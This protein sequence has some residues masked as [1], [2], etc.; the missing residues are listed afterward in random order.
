M[1]RVDG[2]SS[3]V[4]RGAPYFPN[5]SVD[6]S[7]LAP[8]ASLVTESPRHHRRVLRKPWSPPSRAGRTPRS[9]GSSR[10]ARWSPASAATARSRTY[11]SSRRACMS[12]FSSTTPIGCSLGSASARLLCLLRAS[13]AARLGSSSLPGSSQEE[14]GP[15]LEAPTAIALGARMRASRL[16]TRR[17]SQHRLRPCT[18]AYLLLILMEWGYSLFQVSHDGP[19]L[20]PTRARPPR[21]LRAL[22]VLRALRPLRALRTSP[23]PGAPRTL[24]TLTCLL[25]TLPDRRAA[26]GHL[27]LHVR[28]R[29]ALRPDRRPLR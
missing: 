18:Q 28:L 7:F 8:N 17:F 25:L 10:V 14:A 15:A 3:C 5:A 23:G 29:G 13:L 9:S 12:N 6:S 24:R 21:P 20:I 1:G 22:R 11:S 19:M 2:G 27:R 4:K 26:L 16:Q